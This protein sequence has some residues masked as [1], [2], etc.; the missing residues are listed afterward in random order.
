VLNG[1][2]F[3]YENECDYC[4]PC[5]SGI[6]AELKEQEP[7][8][9]QPVFYNPVVTS[10]IEAT[11]TSSSTVI[12]SSTS[13]AVT[14]NKVGDD[15]GPDKCKEAVPTKPQSRPDE[16]F[17]ARLRASMANRNEALQQSEITVK[18]EAAMSQHRA[19]ILSDGR[20]GGIA[21][22]AQ[23]S[24]QATPHQDPKKKKKEASSPASDDNTSM[25]NSRPP[26]AKM[27]LRQEPIPKKTRRET[28]LE[29]LLADQER[30]KKP[31]K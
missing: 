3:P 23:A 21:G 26:R 15:I 14:A 30:K 20:S 5:R 10:H 9:S 27:V 12:M 1:P 7:N 18:T 8:S 19:R 29:E 24:I 6:F 25:S 4:G 11:S 22:I 31:T 13:A 2:K 28:E 16:D 17:G